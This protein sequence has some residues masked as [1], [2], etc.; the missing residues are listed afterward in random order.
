MRWGVHGSAKGEGGPAEG[1]WCAMATPLLM[2]TC[3]SVINIDC[4]YDSWLLFHFTGLASG[5]KS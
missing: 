3:Q 4:T 5:V 1:Q 2:T